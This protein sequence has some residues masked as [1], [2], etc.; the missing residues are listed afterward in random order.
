MA[1]DTVTHRLYTVS[2]DFQ[3]PD[4]AAAPPAAAPAGVAV[5]PPQCPIRSLSLSLE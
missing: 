1:I 2:Q 5:D 4:P 3:A